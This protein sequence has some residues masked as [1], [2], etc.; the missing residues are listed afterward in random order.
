MGSAIARANNLGILYDK[1]GL[2]AG[3]TYVDIAGVT[4]L[5][6]TLTGSYTEQVTVPATGGVVDY[7]HPYVGI[8]DAISMFVD[9]A[10]LVATSVKM[11]L[12]GRYSGTTAW[13]DI[14]L[15]RE[16]TGAVAAEQTFAATGTYLVQTASILAVSQIRV[17][18]EA[19]GGVEYGEGDSIVVRAW[20]Q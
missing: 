13:T 16:D 2:P 5:V 12:Q 20:V 7:S 19:A 15:V 3:A 17:L 14:Q 18:A 11:K 6:G 4:Q 10:L 9:V 8:R 1:N